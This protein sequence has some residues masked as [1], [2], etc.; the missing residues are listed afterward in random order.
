MWSRN[1]HVFT[2]HG[3]SSKGNALK[4]TTQIEGMQ[5]HSIILC[6]SNFCDYCL[7]LLH[8]CTR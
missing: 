3:S 6:R 4:N 7:K 1:P 5:A 8:A 2:C